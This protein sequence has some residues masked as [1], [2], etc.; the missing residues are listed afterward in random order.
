MISRLGA[1]VS[2]VFARFMPDPFV[3]AVLLSLLTLVLA[4]LLGDFAGKPAEWSRGRALVEAWRSERGLWTFL[5]FGMQMCLVLVTGH[6]LAASRPVGAM[7]RAL[8]DR[9]RTAAGA[10]LM[11]AAVASVCSLFNWG[12]GLIVGAVLARE[13][14]RSLRRRG[15]PHHYPL[16]VAAGF[17]GFLPWHGGLSG[18]GPLSMT[19]PAAMAKVLPP[20]TIARLQEAGYAQGVPLADTTFSMM[21]IVITLG[22]VVIGPV[23]AAMLTPRRVQEMAGYAG[24]DR[25]AA[26]AGGAGEGRAPGLGGWL[27]R[28]WIVNGVLGAALLAAA[29]A[30]VLGGGA[31]EVITR[32]Q[33]VGLNEVNVVTM[34]AGLLLHRSPR[35][36]VAAVEDA[37]RGCAGII[38]QFPVYGGVVALLTASGLAGQIA[39]GLTAHGDVRSLPVFTFACAAVLNMFIPSGGGQ[40]GV[41]G[42]V[43]L[44]SGLALGVPPGTM[45]MAVAYGDQLTNMLQVF[46]ALPLLAV[47]GV[48]AREIVGYTTVVMVAAGVWIAAVLWVMGAG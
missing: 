23:M 15:V 30:Y 40:W 32:L 2:R 39:G 35:E 34:A 13:V 6:A 27:D 43:A 4:L 29:G 9:P 19:S 11:T 26:G 1:L 18:S 47:C 17:V 8:A 24:D 31:A 33:R 7:L 38:V 48:K 16:I 41:Q 14:G 10:A 28:A 42:P 44:E 20:E 25:P 36:Y 5:A 22:L 3:I 12:L 46:W 21:N 45:V 37:A